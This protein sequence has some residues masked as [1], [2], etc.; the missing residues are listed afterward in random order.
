[1]H[2]DKVIEGKTVRLRAV[3]ERDAQVTFEMRSDPEKS[4]YIH[5]AKGTVDDQLAFIKA[6]REREGDWLFLVEDLNGK[7]IGMKGVYDYDPDKKVVETGRFMNFGSQVQGIEALCLSFDFA[8]D[9]LGVDHIIMSALEENTNMRGIQDR[10][11]VKVTHYIYNPEF[12]CHSV[13][14][15]LTRE[16]FAQSRP[17]VMALVDRFASRQ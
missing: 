17:K 8:F 5:G 2:Y 10:F 3:E 9:V 13:Y 16:A 7:P 11:G 4:R 12:G 14:S 1:M 6:Q 15:V